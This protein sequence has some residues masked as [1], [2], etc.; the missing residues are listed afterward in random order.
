MVMDNLMDY[1]RSSLHFL[2]HLFKYF[3]YLSKLLL[4]SANLLLRV[5]LLISID[6]DKLGLS[7]KIN[8]HLSQTHIPYTILYSI[9]ANFT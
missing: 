5:V 7:F 3:N 1:F 9:S 8:I 2:L 4:R 6:A